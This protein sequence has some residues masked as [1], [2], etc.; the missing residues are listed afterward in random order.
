MEATA[1]I[2]PVTPPFAMAHLRS[3]NVPAL[4]PFAPICHPI[5][6][7]NRGRLTAGP[8]VI[9][10]LAQP[11]RSA[12]LSALVRAPP[13]RA[14]DTTLPTP[15]VF[16]PRGTQTATLAAEPFENLIGARP[17][18]AKRGGRPAGKKGGAGAGPGGL[19]VTLAMEP[20]R[21]PYEPG[22]GGA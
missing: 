18:A 14:R 3:R 9:A 2:A 8:P 15:Q 5:A 20:F 22:A 10:E 17:S 1:G 7:S 6:G 21:K 16:S 11:A 19:A 12:L 4:A 13:G